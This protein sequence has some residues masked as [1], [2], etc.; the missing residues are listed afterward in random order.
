MDI[1]IGHDKH[2]ERFTVY[3]IQE[4]IVSNMPDS[5]LEKFEKKFKMASITNCN[6]IFNT[7]DHS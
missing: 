5:G 3:F 2:F 6:K 7:K 1:W 4:K